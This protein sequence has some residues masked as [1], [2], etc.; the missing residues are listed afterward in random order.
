M[1]GF[2]KQ[3]H[4]KDIGA[5]VCV[6][7]RIRAIRVFILVNSHRLCEVDIIISTLSTRW[8]EMS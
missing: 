8:A 7:R 2:F 1:I 6:R 3:A 5:N 4:Y